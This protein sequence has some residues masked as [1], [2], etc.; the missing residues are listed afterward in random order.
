MPSH[1]SN[2]LEPLQAFLPLNSNPNNQIWGFHNTLDEGLN[3]SFS[4]TRPEFLNDLNW[5]E[6]GQAYWVHTAEATTVP[7]VD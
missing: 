6:P 1:V 3:Y 7:F 4:T 2:T 5:I